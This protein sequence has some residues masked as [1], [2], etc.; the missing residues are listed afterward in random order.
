LGQKTSESFV[1]EVFLRLIDSGPR[2]AKF[3][4]CLSNWALLNLDRPNRFV[5]ELNQIVGIKKV[6]FGEQRVADFF[7]MAMEGA[8]G[9]ERFD[10]L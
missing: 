9:S 1:P 4:G 6:M 3:H 5:F 7:R 8:T 10:F 2:E